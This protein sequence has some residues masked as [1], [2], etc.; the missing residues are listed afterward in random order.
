LGI[1]RLKKTVSYAAVLVWHMTQSVLWRLLQ[2]QGKDYMRS[3]LMTSA[4]PPWVA[5]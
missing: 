2:K 5:A 1:V 3:R 4:G